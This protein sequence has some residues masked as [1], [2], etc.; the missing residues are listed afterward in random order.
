MNRSLTLTLLI[1]L[2]VGCARLPKDQKVVSLCFRN[3]PVDHKAE[4]A[5]EQI[6]IVAP[7]VVVHRVRKM[8]TNWTVGV[9]RPQNGSARC[10]LGCDHLY[11][12]V[13]DINSFDGLVSLYVPAKDSPE[14][15]VRI[16]ITRGPLG[17]GRIINLAEK[18][19]VLK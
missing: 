13:S 10:V 19:L 6:E 17:P 15:K 16:F 12:A 7:S 2:A 9:S 1:L 3:D 8:P 5:I 4:E 11:F 14:I 18:D